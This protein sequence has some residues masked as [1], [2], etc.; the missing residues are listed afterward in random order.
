MNRLITTILWMSL[1]LTASSFG[2]EKE[3]LTKEDRKAIVEYLKKTRNELIDKVKSL[4]HEQWTYK[5]GP[6]VWSV[7]EICEHIL[8]AESVV[9]K[10]VDNQEGMSYKPELITN[11]RQRAEEVIAF[12]VGRETKLKAPEP[13]APS[14]LVSSRDEFIRSFENRRE[15]TIHFVK[16]IDK[17]I[18]AYYEV[19][20]P[21]GEV[22]G[23]HWLMFISAHTQRHILQLNEVLDNPD[24]P[25][26]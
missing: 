14:G 10:R 23:Y 1:W 8:K 4:T 12:I 17:P 9:L 21:I 3:S 6:D 13:V 26:R 22:N 15:E 20:G 11:Y 2:T 25:N 5:P 16:S 7:G 18:K 24:F 19:F